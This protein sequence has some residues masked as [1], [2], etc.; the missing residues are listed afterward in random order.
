MTVTI[1]SS[2][3]ILFKHFIALVSKT[4]A[5]KSSHSLIIDGK[6]V[7]ILLSCRSYIFYQCKNVKLLTNTSCDFLSSVN[8]LTVGERHGIAMKHLTENKTKIIQDMKVFK[9]Y[10]FFLLNSTDISSKV[11][12][13]GD[14]V[15]NM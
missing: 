9:Q 15:D 1:P 8:V 10:D 14:F 11:V 6:H 5:S 7:K 13:K 2:S 3:I 4:M 12:F